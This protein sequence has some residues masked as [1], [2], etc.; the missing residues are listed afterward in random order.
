[1]QNIKISKIDLD[2]KQ[3]EYY[4]G[5][6]LIAIDCE[7]MGLNIN[8]DRLCMVQIADANKQAT[9]VQIALGQKEAPNLK[10]LLEANSPMKIFHYARTDIA[11]LKAWLGIEVNSFFCTKVASKLARTYTDK[12]GLKELYKEVNGKEM[13][14]AQQ[15][16]DWGQDEV[17][18]EQIQYAADDVLHLIPIYEKL[19]AMLLREG[20]WEL[21]SRCI[22]TVPLFAELDSHGYSLVLEH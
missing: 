8:R 22:A 16:S 18:K 9:L 7:M 10:K 12:H 14:K 1:M 11:W 13:N 4:L 19:K 5:R 2:D 17:S 21:A 20:K 6:D 15:S 3:L